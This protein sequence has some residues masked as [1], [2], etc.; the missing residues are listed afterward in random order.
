MIFFSVIGYGNRAKF[1]QIDPVVDSSYRLQLRSLAE[2]GIRHFLNR[3]F[4]YKL[5]IRKRSDF[6]TI[7]FVVLKIR[8]PFVVA[9]YLRKCFSSMTKNVII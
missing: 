8:V 1:L 2:S 7:N 4:I 3:H 9:I 5:F 6:S